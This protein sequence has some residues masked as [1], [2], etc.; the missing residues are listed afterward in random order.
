M[1]THLNEINGIPDA[2]ISMY[3]SKRT[4]TRQLEEDI[5]G[6]CHDVLDYSGRIRLNAEKQKLEIFSRWMDTLIKWGRKHNTM[7]RFIDLSITVEGLHRA[8]QDDWDAHAKRFD[9]RIIRTST[10]LANFKYEMSEWYQD[11]IL[12]TDLAL[13]EVGIAIPPEVFIDGQKY[14]KAV[15]GYI[16]EGFQENLDAKRG[17]YML[18]IPSNFIF[19]I[20]LTE[21]AHVYKERQE[22][23]HSNP[24]VK[25]CCESIASQ[26]ESCHQQFNR[27]LFLEI[28]N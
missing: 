21:W 12:P 4:W 20:N 28:L 1:L 27:G 18:C 15:N 24:E 25:Q 5:R 6:L 11:K 8:G 14:I 17:L 3:M 7:L 23:G 22:S 19:K 16:K 13:R 2:I 26:L 9:N 10:R